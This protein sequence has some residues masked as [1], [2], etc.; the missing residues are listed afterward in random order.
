MAIDDTKTPSSV[1]GGTLAPIPQ[2][3]AATPPFLPEQ[4]TSDI[5]KRILAKILQPHSQLPQGQPPQMPGR[6]PMNTNLA[7]TKSEGLQLFL[8]NLGATVSN[9][10]A[11]HKERQIR[12]AMG[13]YSALTGAWERAQ[14]ASG[15]DPSKADQIFNQDSIVYGI[16]HDPK[17]VKN[18]AQAESMDYL[19]PEKTTVYGEAKKR[20]VQTHQAHGIMKILQ[21][22][23]I[24][25][26]SQPQLSGQEQQQFAQEMAH[27]VEQTARP[28]PMD[29]K[30]AMELTRS[31]SFADEQGQAVEDL[32]GKTNP[33]TK[34]PYT[35]DEAVQ[36]VRGGED[37]SREQIVS[38]LA[39]Q[40]YNVTFDEQGNASVKPMVGFKD[41][42][43]ETQDR[44][45]LSRGLMATYGDAGQ[46]TGVQEVP[47]YL[48]FQKQLEKVKGGGRAKNAGFMT[49]YAAYRFYDEAI[50]ENP[51]LLP[52]ITPMISSALRQAGIEVGPD[53][54][55]AFKELPPNMPMNEFGQ[56]IGTRMPG[57]PLAAGRINTSGL[58]AQRFLSDE[59]SVREEVAK[60]AKYLGPAQG[61]VSVR[62]LLGA[63]GSTGDPEADRA[64]SKLRTDLQ[65]VSTNAAAF[66]VV[67]VRPIE[68]F[69]E[70]ADAGKMSPEALY[71]YLDGIH[72]WAVT[73]AKQGTGKPTAT[74]EEMEESGAGKPGGA[75]PDYIF[76]G[77]KLVPN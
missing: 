31:R 60:N 36:K 29:A 48:S 10:V 45:L 22:L 71:G 16:L 59:G 1:L 28:T 13:D 20:W 18:M 41:K 64:L 67:A 2:S 6:T 42:G 33:E 69:M 26:Q 32:M 46:V 70:L 15:G 72:K 43:R 74:P 77:G 58:F 53:F 19:N 24:A 56:A 47:G 54:E 23:H 39:K 68:H 55:K 51:N 27:R 50:K 49:M 3:S 57:S 38:G 40:G 37:K 11:A 63:V 73:A 4:S 17:K 14:D 5:V 61:R 62:F 52:V 66:H 35:R 30:T 25:A 34:K 12:A 65:M 9:A 76:K 7:R 75:K 44:T 21:K 8:H